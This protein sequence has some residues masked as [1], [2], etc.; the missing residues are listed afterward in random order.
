MWFEV[1]CFCHY[2]LCALT[3]CTVK[4]PPQEQTVLHKHWKLWFFLTSHTHFLSNKWEFFWH[5]LR[6]HLPLGGVKKNRSYL[7]ALA[8]CNLRTSTSHHTDQNQSQWRL[9]ELEGLGYS[10]LLNIRLAGAFRLT[11]GPQGAAHLTGIPPW[12]LPN[13]P[14]SISAPSAPRLGTSLRDAG[15]ALVGSSRADGQ[16]EQ[17]IPRVRQPCPEQGRSCKPRKECERDLKSH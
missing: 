9:I 8:P 1:F 17:S 6:K 16:G 7:N 13:R 3:V 15:T 4:K 14:C 2:Y 12:D 5:S 11:P 10:D